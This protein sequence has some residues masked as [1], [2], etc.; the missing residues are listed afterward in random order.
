MQIDIYNV[1]KYIDVKYVSV[2]VQLRRF[3]NEEEFKG[4]DEEC[5]ILLR[6]LP[7]FQIVEKLMR[8]E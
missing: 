4:G 3:S 5:T 8:Y 7:F 1:Q 2:C 6:D